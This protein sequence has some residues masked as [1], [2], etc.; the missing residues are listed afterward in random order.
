M[1]NFT[2]CF[3][4][5]DYILMEGALGERLKREY[6]LEIDTPVVMG[7]LVYS[8]EGRHALNDKLDGSAE[9]KSSSPEYLA[10]CIK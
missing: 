10:E 8:Q 5:N 3:K 6:Q 2:N 7:N 1:N 9:L 4:N